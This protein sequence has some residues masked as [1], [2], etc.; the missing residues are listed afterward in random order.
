[1][2]AMVWETL[3]ES[4]PTGRTKPPR[5]TFNFEVGDKVRISNA[6][7]TFRKGYLPKWTEEIFEITRRIP[8]NPPVY[9]L[10]DYD[11]EEIEGSF[12]EE[13]LQKITK[14]DDMYRIERVLK[15]RRKNGKLQYFVKWMGYPDKFSS[16]VDHIHQL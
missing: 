7:K 14:T 4:K 15:R 1:M 13:E 6:A 8:K 9:K 3:Y 10:K 16:W 2:K 5:I 12:Y 11:G